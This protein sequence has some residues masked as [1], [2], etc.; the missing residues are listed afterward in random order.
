[1]DLTNIT[2]EDLLCD[3]P[4][5]IDLGGKDVE[6]ELAQIEEQIAKAESLLFLPYKPATVEPSKHKPPKKTPLPVH[7]RTIL[8]LCGGTGAWS[9]PYRDAGYDVRVITFPDHDVFTYQPPDNVYG[10]LAAPTCTHFSLARTTAK[11]P[12]DLRGGFQLVKRCLEIIWEA[13]FNGTLT[14]WALENPLGYLRQLLGLPPLTFQPCDYGDPYTKRTDLWGYFKMPRQR[15]VKL[16]EEQKQLCA[17]N[18]RPL[19]EI[20]DGYKLPPDIPR[21]AVRRAITSPAFAQA[22][23]RA[24]P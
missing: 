6:W 12:R 15:P 3:W 1:M 7:E 5:E 21:H 10:I 20:P 9:K 14:F 16:T 13:R 23:F 8:D 17:M 2:K 19:P 4:E 11:T 24:N 22:F 18:N